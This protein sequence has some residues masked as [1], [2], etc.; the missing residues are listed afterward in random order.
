MVCSKLIDRMLPV[1]CALAVVV[2]F[3]MPIHAHGVDLNNDAALLAHQILDDSRPENE[4]K[5]I[6]TEHPNLSLEL[7]EALVADLPA[8]DAKEEYRRIPWIWRVTVAAGKRNNVQEMK[9]IVN[10]TLPQTGKPLRD[11]QAVV[12][13]GGIINGIGLVGA[14][15]DEQIAHMTAADAALSTRWQQTLALAGDMADNSSVFNGTRYDAQRIIGL[16]SWDRRGAQLCRYLRKGPG[17]DDEL[18]QGAI[19]GLGTMRSP[20]VAGAILSEF[21][22]FNAE[23]RGFALDALLKDGQRMSALLDAVETGIVKRSDLGRARV[24]K[25]TH[26]T[27]PAIGARAR[28][29]FGTSGG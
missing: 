12:M 9:P 17:I 7:L 15:P 16:D 26:S 6:I 28:R 13:G 11:W 22:R 29:L 23:N 4:R 5:K 2:Y 10:F 8:H 27:E 20:H 18:V 14:W 19:G 24:E 3:F 25:L 21:A 1:S